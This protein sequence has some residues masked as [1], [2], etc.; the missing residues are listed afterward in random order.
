MMQF[1]SHK[2]IAIQFTIEDNFYSNNIILM[3]LFAHIRYTYLFMCYMV[4]NVF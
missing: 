3:L 4:Y 2:I 1:I